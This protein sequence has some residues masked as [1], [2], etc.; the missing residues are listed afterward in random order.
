MALIVLYL[1]RFWLKAKTI[2]G[3]VC[4]SNR[5]TK[6]KIW[7]LH[8]L[9]FL[10]LI[11]SPYLLADITSCEW[12]DRGVQNS[13]LPIAA[14]DGSYASGVVIARNRVLTAAHVII[15][16]QR[17]FV[18]IDYDFTLAEVLLIDEEKDLAVMAVNT[19]G[20]DPIQLSRRD[21]YDNEPMW[22]IGFPHARSKTTSVGKFKTKKNGVLHTSVHIDAGESGGGLLNCEGGVFFLAGMLRGYG[23]YTMGQS[24]IKIDNHSVSVAASEIDRFMTR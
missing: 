12:P 17:T 19:R 5:I 16:S 13:I 24:T 2:G 22:A 23:A 9:A 20:I 8:L 18:G 6:S 7:C 11:F 21:P 14:D 1:I 15:D 4:M 3:M 10:H